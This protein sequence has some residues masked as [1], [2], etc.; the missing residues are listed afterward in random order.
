MNNIKDNDTIKKCTSCQMC[1][2]ICPVNAIDVVLDINGFY[3]PNVNLEKCIGC[4]KCKSVCYKFDT[5]VKISD[6]YEKTYGCCEKDDKLLKQVTSGGIA[7]LLAKEAINRGY[8]V[9]GVSYNF[10]NNTAEAKISDTNIDQF[11]G[12]KY[13]QAYTEQAYKAALSDRTG[14][15]MVF[16]TPCQ[17]YSLNKATKL[18]GTRYNYIFV[19]LFCHG[20]P[21]QLLWNKCI[22]HVQNKLKT[23]KFDKVEFRSK[24]MGWHEFSLYFKSGKQEYITKNEFDFFYT[25][26]FSDTILNEA[27]ENCQLRSTLEYTDIRLG[28]F[29]GYEYD[30][31]NNGVSAVVAV[32]KNGNEWL[33]QLKDNKIISEH[34][35]NE[36]IKNQSY[37]RNY[38]VDVSLR[39]LL[40]DNF[41][42]DMKIDQIYRHYCSLVTPKRRIKRVM[43]KSLYILPQ[44]I[45]FLI[46]QSKHRRIK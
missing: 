12:S 20:C 37:G 2:A 24:R 31:D 29:W 4:G 7:H 42:S 41:K 1:S 6:L 22:E 13:I 26:F 3:R 27:C 8:N 14:K 28:D 18:M 5:S 40:F 23:K 11:K 15:Y 10:N 46:R 30:L 39:E 33:S 16:G 21:T 17:I 32:T 43:K 44:K 9:I 45:R 25:F 34:S 38:D 19:D 35:L 36:V